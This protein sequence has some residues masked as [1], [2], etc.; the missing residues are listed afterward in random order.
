MR[1]APLRSSLT[2]LL[3]AVALPAAADEAYVCEGGRIVYVKLGQ[4]EALRR[5]DP[6]IAA[7][8]G[9]TVASPTRAPAGRDGKHAPAPA[10]ASAPQVF[11]VAGTG[12]VAGASATTIAGAGLGTAAD[13]GPAP[14]RAS[15]GR[16]VSVAAQPAARQPDKAP[17]RPEAHPDT[18]FRNVRLVN[19][20]PGQSDVY[21]HER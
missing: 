16:P 8:F 6:C 12:P 17:A 7:Y 5:S 19:P 3:A 15:R 2:L 21:R 13:R 11:T 20:S 9:E 18:D 1:A 4:V 10:A 14:A